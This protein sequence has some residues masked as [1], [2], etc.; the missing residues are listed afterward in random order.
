MAYKGF[1]LLISSLLVIV[2][3]GFW[4]CKETTI[5]PATVKDT[6]INGQRILTFSGYSWLVEN[7]AEM[8]EGPGQT[9]L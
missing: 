9:F 4:G 8:T 5:V 7:S 2:F 3:L 1:V 6:I